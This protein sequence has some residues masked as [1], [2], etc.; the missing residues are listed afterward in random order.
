MNGIGTLL[1]EDGGSV[2][3]TGFAAIGTY[4]GFPNEEDGGMGHVIVDSTAALWWIAGDLYVGLGGQGTLTVARGGSV[5]VDGDLYHNSSGEGTLEIELGARFDYVVPAI[6]VAGAAESLQVNV[7]LV[8]DFLPDVG[9]WFVIAQ[10]ADG[11]E[12]F[13]FTLP[14]IA[15]NRQWL[16][17]QD[18]HEVILSVI[19]RASCPEDLVLPLGIEQQD[20]NAVLNRWGDPAC[21][22]GGPAY[23][24]PE[25]LAAPDGI[26]RQDLNA[27][28]NRWGDPACEQ[29]RSARRGHSGA[30]NS[31]GNG[32]MP[33]GGHASRPHS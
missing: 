4:P 21:E 2:F 18:A 22:P 26:E 28:L 31:P 14:P 24:C 19:A 33:G 6:L 8:D 32:A 27:V 15:P 3:N 17:T 5:R 16:I 29:A 25:D 12:P 13:D 20:L 7:S 23:P 10:A 9:D 11:M 30:R 1:I